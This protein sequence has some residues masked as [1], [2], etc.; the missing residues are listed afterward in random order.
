[1]I[2]R[3]EF[4]HLVTRLSG[5]QH[6]TE[7]DTLLA[8]DEALRAEITQLRDSVRYAVADARPRHDGG[9]HE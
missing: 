8:H 4:V 2:S 6:D 3:D 5:E 1:M 9:E 7:R